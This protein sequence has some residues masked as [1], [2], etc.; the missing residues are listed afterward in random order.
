MKA[1]FI[2]NGAPI[3]YIPTTDVAAGSVVVHGDLVG[4]TKLNIKANSLG[5]LHVVGVYDVEKGNLAFALGAKV[6]W[7][8]TTNS[9]TATATDTLLGIAVQEAVVGD[10]FVRVRI[11]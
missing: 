3:D 8:T 5:A 11:N 1:R 6:Y 9:V 2:H 4:I 10:E 7:S